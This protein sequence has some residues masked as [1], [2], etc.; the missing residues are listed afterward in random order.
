MDQSKQESEMK[1][2]WNVGTA[3]SHEAGFVEIPLRDT[4]EV[5]PIKVE[6]YVKIEKKRERFLKSRA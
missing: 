5:S 2:P 1:Q 3:C 6:K 4:D